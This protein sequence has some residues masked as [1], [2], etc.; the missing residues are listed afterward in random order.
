MV[1]AIY[2][3]FKNKEALV[4]YILKEIM[5]DS[6]E[7]IRKVLEA[8]IPLKEKFKQVILLKEEMNQESSVEFYAD[9]YAKP[10]SKVNKLLLKERENWDKMLRKFYK[11]AQSRGEIR[12]DLNIEFLMYMIENFQK[13]FSDRKFQDLFPDFSSMT[14]EVMTFFYYGILKK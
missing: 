6:K 11:A 13:M 7:R 10:N 14:H 9:I 4:I 5:E 8:P 12:E 3:Y 2:K 1:K